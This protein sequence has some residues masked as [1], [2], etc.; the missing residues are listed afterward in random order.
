MRSCGFGDSNVSSLNLE[1]VVHAER[2]TPP[3]AKW[4]NI[5]VE[6]TK[7]KYPDAEVVDYLHVGQED[8]GNHSIEKFKLWLKDKDKEFGVL[9][10]IEFNKSTEQLVDI[11]YKEVAR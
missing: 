2:P 11:T 3:Y 5:A 6:K 7:E 8:R 1:T 10:H 9:V 4:G